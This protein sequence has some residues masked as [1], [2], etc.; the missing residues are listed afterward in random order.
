MN[1]LA[2][3][4]RHELIYFCHFFCSCAH[5]FF[6]NFPQFLQE[7]KRF[8]VLSCLDPSR[9]VYRTFSN[10][11]SKLTGYINP[12]VLYYVKKTSGRVK[13]STTR[14]Q[15][16]KKFLISYKKVMTINF[17]SATSAADAPEFSRMLRDSR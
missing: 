11:R 16:V 9:K 1:Y 12:I 2:F 8:L 14:H 7:F 13:L 4:L 5:L 15:I 10:R 17:R 6:F 3:C